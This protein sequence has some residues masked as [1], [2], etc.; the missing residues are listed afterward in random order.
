MRIEGG[1]KTTFDGPFAET[2]EHLG[3]Y[4]MIEE[5]GLDA[6]VEWA[7]R[8]P[9]FEFLN[10]TVEVRQVAEMPSPDQD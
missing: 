4:Y 3:G 9:A 6:A 10:A 7:H 2:K 1:N 5:D 8:L